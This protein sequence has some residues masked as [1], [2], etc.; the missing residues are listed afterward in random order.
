MYLNHFNLKR[1]P[2]HITP[3]PYFLYLSPSHKEAFASM[4]YGLKKRKGFVAV[5]GEVGLGKTT[6]L[7]AFLEQR[8][9]Q[10]KIKTIFV[11]NSNVSFKG[12]LKI[13]YAELG[14]T[15]PGQGVYENR[16]VELL[17]DIG[18]DD[19]PSDEIFDIVQHLHTQL[20]HEYQ[21][22]FNIILVIDEAQNMPVCTLENLRM[23][24]NLET[25]QD[26]LIQIFLIGQPEL[27]KTLN[28]KE[29]RQLKQRIAIR[30][31]LK[32]LTNKE[33]ID[34]I[35]HRLK[36]AG[37]AGE[38]I[39]SKQALRTVCKLAR[40]TPR[41][42]NIL[43]D[44]AL[45]T[46]FGYGRNKVTAGVVK[47]VNEDLE[48]RAFHPKKLRGLL[49]PAFAALVVVLVGLA[50]LQVPQVRERA[51]RLLGSNQLLEDGLVFFGQLTSITSRPDERA[52]SQQARPEKEAAPQQPART[53][54][55]QARQKAAASDGL[56]TAGNSSGMDNQDQPLS[57]PAS[58]PDSNRTRVS[59][60]A[61]QRSAAGANSTSAQMPGTVDAREAGPEPDADQTAE[62]GSP[63][64]KADTASPVPDKATDLPAIDYET[65]FIAS[66]LRKA[67]PFFS[68]LSQ[69][70][71]QILVEMA[72]QT[73]IQGLLTFKR[74]IAALERGD[75]SEAAR[76]M[77]S[78]QWG[79][80]AGDRATALAEI[81]RS[82]DEAALEAWME[83]VEEG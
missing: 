46:A 17:Q 7:R 73:S 2:F 66:E 43:C 40:G 3:D 13:I 26:K 82:N 62:R 16:T 51:A 54:G 71:R 55:S 83:G 78:S 67:L 80:W 11:F 27:E 32:P 29:L 41:K 79:N 1:E 63:R 19:I 4:I 57:E 64:V 35:Q 39:F 8:G 30:A 69:V 56:G 5:I 48:G 23:L 33:A 58:Q 65:L 18:E 25:A 50:L 68:D 12:L 52:A 36:K 60:P 21:Q 44:N 14:Y 15:L 49:K 6:V 38:Q 42:I 81:M 28:R 45:I 76:Q 47:E 9:S 10:Q 75:F 53:N 59:A 24:S 37:A 74:M 31:I 22:G 61:G 34:Y 20:I 70:R 72:K 77:V